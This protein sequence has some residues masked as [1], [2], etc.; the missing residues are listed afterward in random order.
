M[1]NINKEDLDSFEKRRNHTV[2]VIECGR[3]G[4]AHARLFAD[5][6][7]RVIG[8]NTNPH[9][10]ELLKKGQTPFLRNAYRVLEKHVKEGS[11]SASSDIR[12]ATSE[13]DMV[14]ITVQTVIDQRRKPDYSLLEKTCR[15]VGMGLKKGSLIIFASPTGPGIVEGSMREVLEK[16]SGLRIGVDF[17]LAYG[18]LQFNSQGCNA[19]VVVGAID[20][21]SLRTAGLVFRS[22]TNSE[23]VEIS[24]IKTVEA[25]VLFRNVNS[26]INQALSNE[27]AFLC[28]KLKIDFI[29]VLNVINKDGIS[30]LP[31]PGMM[32]ISSRRDL[33]M[34]QEEAENV[35]LN[36]HL[37]SS[38]SRIN[39][40]VVES[41]FRL[42]KN[43]LK[44]C[45]KTVRGSKISIL[46]I[47]KRPNTKEPPATLTKN[48]ITL[49]KKKVRAVQVYDP[50][51]STKELAEL[52]FETQKLSKVVEKTDCVL[53]L[54]G[55]SKFER[56]NLKKVKLLAK[57]SPAIVDISHVIDPFKAERHG[58]VYRGL[59]RGVWTK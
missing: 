16:S 33:Y 13:S 22:L 24:N 50:Y 8:V 48:V 53:I 59:G 17:G 28:E 25:L 20:R 27:L 45:G 21:L 15:E 19:R 31:L 14:V 51:F 42:V 32:D 41:T 35:N 56:L 39:D 7:F 12:K 36:L 37:A 30:P 54:T 46:G 57:K 6:G 23:I 40:E 4:V 29:E 49:L 10:L 5:A 18:A 47:S 38:A 52:G 55:H 26:E 43:A 9:N 58:F 1:M 2:S 44:T 34:L 3:I 11:F